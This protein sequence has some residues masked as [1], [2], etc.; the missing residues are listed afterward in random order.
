MIRRGYEES[1]RRRLH[2]VYDD[3][4]QSKLQKHCISPFV[5]CQESHIWEEGDV[6]PH[7]VCPSLATQ[8]NRLDM[9]WGSLRSM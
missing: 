8:S 1:V 4:C 6:E 2:L 7:M 5:V 3:N 9:K